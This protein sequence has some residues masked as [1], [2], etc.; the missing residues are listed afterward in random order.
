MLP[1]D[2]ATAEFYAELVSEDEASG[3]AAGMADAQ[4]PEAV[5]HIGGRPALRPMGQFRAR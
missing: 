2:L 1:F 3:R 5:Q 4:L